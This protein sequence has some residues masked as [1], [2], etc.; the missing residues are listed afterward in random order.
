MKASRYA[1]LV[2]DP[3]RLG[4]E[5]VRVQ[6]VLGDLSEPASFR[7]ALRGVKTVV[8]LAASLRDQRRA[9]IEELNGVATMRLIRAAERG[10]GA[11]RL[12]LRARREPQQ[13]LALPALEGAGRA[14]RE[15]VGLRLD[16]LRAVARVL[17]GGPLDPRCSDRC[18]CY[19]WSRS[20]AEDG[21]RFQP[22]WAEDAA[23][24]VMQRLRGAGD[25]QRR[26]ELA[27]P[28]TL[29][30]DGDRANPRRAPRP[31]TAARAGAAVRGARRPMDGRQG[32]GRPRLR[33]L[34]RSAS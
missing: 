3:R 14:G 34:G 6:I 5:R 20:R 7:N 29:S 4:D 12:L 22:V 27:G 30:Y 21:A 10:G 23:D 33:H 28:E 15:R 25:D 24:A 8:H 19:R 31:R 16:R 13:P 2:R 11:L 1:A 32:G 9:S 26:F 18:R 17:A